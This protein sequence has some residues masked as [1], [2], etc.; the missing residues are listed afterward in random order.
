[1]K[2]HLKHMAIAGGTILVLLLA[3]GVDL[4]KALPYALLLACP[5]GMVV[6]MGMMSRRGGHDH[7]AHGSGESAATTPAP[8]ARPGLE[9]T[10]ENHERLP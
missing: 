8:G 5:I 6:M 4:G 9:I 1:M 2:H 3:F 7:A 10:R